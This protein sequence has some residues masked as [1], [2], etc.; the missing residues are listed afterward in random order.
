M[1][2]I[3][4]KIKTKLTLIANKATKDQEKY[5]YFLEDQKIIF[6]LMKNIFVFAN[7]IEKFVNYLVNLIEVLMLIK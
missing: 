7:L 1:Y 4:S 3:N 2:L 6:F 5:S